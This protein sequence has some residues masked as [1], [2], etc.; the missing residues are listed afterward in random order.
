MDNVQH[1][2]Q[3]CALSVVAKKIFYKR[4]FVTHNEY[5]IFKDDNKFQKKIYLLISNCF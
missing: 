4:R 2:V 3:K 1:N 5:Q